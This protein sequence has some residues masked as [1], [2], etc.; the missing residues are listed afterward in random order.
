MQLHRFLVLNLA[1][2]KKLSGFILF[3]F[4]KLGFRFLKRIYR[5]DGSQPVNGVQLN[6]P[7]K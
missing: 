5:G 2:F 4:K 3:M 6:K 7:L 1:G